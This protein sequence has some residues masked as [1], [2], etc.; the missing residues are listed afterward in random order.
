M[1]LLSSELLWSSCLPLL[2][3]E[4]KHVEEESNK[5]WHICL[6]LDFLTPVEKGS[7][8]KLRCRHIYD[9]PERHFEQS[10][11]LIVK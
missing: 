5:G 2:T 4:I 8:F 11:K 9:F 1:V 10:V 7:G 6:G 3:E